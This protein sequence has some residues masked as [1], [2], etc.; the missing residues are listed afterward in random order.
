MLVSLSVKN[1]A[2]IDN[3]QIEFEP[4]MTVM[5]GE[6]GA[7]KSLIIDAL[8]LLFGARA[9]SDLIRYG[10]NKASIVG[11]FSNYSKDIINILN[12]IGVDFDE[13]DNLII[14]RELY[15]NGK[16]VCK[17]NSD[18]VTLN[19]LKAIC[20]YVGDI[21]SQN[22]SLGL[23]NPKNYLSF[24]RNAKIDELIIKYQNLLKEYKNIKSL[25]NSKLKHNEEI[26]E[27]MDFLKYQYKELKSYDLNVTEEE[28][29]KNELSS[30]SN[31]E[32]INEAIKS[33]KDIYDKQN[34]LDLIYESL[35]QLN[36]LR[37]YDNKYEDLYKEL[38][39]AYYNIEPAP[40]PDQ[41]SRNIAPA[42]AVSSPTPR[43]WH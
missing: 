3:V 30:L 11:V 13:D 40:T 18:I 32:N 29:L 37:S 26:K 16:S 17:I 41:N 6:T 22:D 10:E 34:A 14:K 8:S 21:H 1:F 5:T 38:E 27:K 9:S 7:G 42:K 43:M 2:I 35:N 33:F 24:I 39:D 36:K 19:D 25:Y 31:Y 23:I 4:N 20:D 15:A 28:D 12:E